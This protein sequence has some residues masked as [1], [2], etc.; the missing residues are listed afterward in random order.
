MRSCNADC[1]SVHILVLV[2]RICEYKMGQSLLRGADAQEEHENPG[3]RPPRRTPLRQLHLYSTTSTLHSLSA[4]P[5]PPCPCSSFSRRTPPSRLAFVAWHPPGVLS[6][7]P[8]RR[9]SCAHCLASLLQ[10]HRTHCFRRAP[11][12]PLCPRRTSRNPN[13]PTR[14]SA[15]LPLA[16]TTHSF[17]PSFNSDALDPGHLPRGLCSLPCCRVSRP[18]PQI[19]FCILQ[20]YPALAF[21]PLHAH[22]LHAHRSSPNP[23]KFNLNSGTSS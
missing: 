10:S 17:W 18:N 3:K 16:Q 1:K 6:C 22:R 14:C 2:L 7:R 23:C 21:L 11:S 5:S 9:F 4:S 19:H 13:N 20:K 12:S 8:H 15:A